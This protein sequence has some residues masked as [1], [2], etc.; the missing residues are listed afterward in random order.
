MDKKPL[1]SDGANFQ[2]TSISNPWQHLQFQPR[3]GA[4][5]RIAKQAVLCGDVTLGDQC[6]VWPFAVIRGDVASIQ[7]GNA[8][9]VQEHV[10]IHVYEGFDVT[11]G[12]QVTIGHGAIVH[13]CHVGNHCL[14]GMHATILNGA[15]IGH[16]CIIGAHALITQNKEIPPYSL[17]LGAPGKVVRNLT[18]SDLEVIRQDAQ[19]YV[20]SLA[21]FPF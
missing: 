13:G 12:D 19:V 7:I 17:V 10:T 20:D 4:H 6:T 9:N 18:P 8:T 16:H 5:T 14:I 15:K 11:I 2:S 21:H 3:L 1:S